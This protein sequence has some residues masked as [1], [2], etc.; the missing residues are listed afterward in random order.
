MPFTA[1]CFVLSAFHLGFVMERFYF[2]SN[3]KMHKTLAEV[4]AFVQFLNEL[5]GAHPDVQLFILP[6]FT[7]LGGLDRAQRPERVWVGAQNMHWAAEGA[8]TGEISAL[9]LRDLGA[10][11][12]MLGHAERRH[13]FG[14]TDVEIRRKV[15]SA[16]GI[17]LRVLLCVGETA[18]QRESGVTGEILALQLKIALHGYAPPPDHLLVAYEPVW[19]I[20]KGGREAQPDE[21]AQSV[22]Q[23]RAVLAAQLGDAAQD[24]PVLYGGSVT[25]RNCGAYVREAAVD[26]LFVG[27]AA[28]TH[29][30]FAAVLRAALAARPTEM[31]SNQAKVI[32]P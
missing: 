27:R 28:W 14:E 7:A 16:A 5:A 24:V 15:E 30:G 31:K 18:G 6:P 23:I 9:M 4:R 29:D 32:R 10:D 13:K 12:V 2:G 11:L 1:F 21:I 25:E 8:Y 26:G 19:A 3:F 22:A 17:G 20:G